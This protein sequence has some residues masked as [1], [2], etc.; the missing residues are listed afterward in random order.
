M[1][2]E[3]RLIV[4]IGYDNDIPSFTTDYV[5]K[6]V[7]HIYNQPEHSVHPKQ[8][9]LATRN[10]IRIASRGTRCT[11][12]TL[13][14]YIVSTINVAML[15]WDVFGGNYANHTTIDPDLVMAYLHQEKEKDETKKYLNIF[16]ITQ[17]QINYDNLL[18]PDMALGAEFE[19]LLDIQNS[20]KKVRARAK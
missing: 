2:K 19:A 5:N 10:I 17:R 13:S 12:W 18:D 20:N 16:D 1:S 9:I 11:I 4:V 14:P 7:G 3:F 6:T 15:A 8:Q